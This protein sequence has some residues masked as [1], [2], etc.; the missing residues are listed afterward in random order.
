MCLLYDKT[1]FFSPVWQPSLGL[2]GTGKSRVNSNRKNKLGYKSLLWLILYQILRENKK[3]HFKSHKA[4]T[5]YLFFLAKFLLREAPLTDRRSWFFFHVC[6]NRCLSTARSRYTAK[7]G[8]YLF[9]LRKER[10]ALLEYK[11][12]FTSSL[13]LL[14]NTNGFRGEEVTATE[15]NEGKGIF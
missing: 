7:V 14:V 13:M 12:I 2:P 11:P 10:T 6:T 3:I 15:G 5:P 1:E 4:E 9:W 8:R